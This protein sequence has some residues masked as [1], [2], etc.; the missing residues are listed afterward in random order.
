LPGSC[1]IETVA[2]SRPENRARNSL[3]IDSPQEVMGQSPT[4]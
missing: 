2:N 1:A 3:V 4:S